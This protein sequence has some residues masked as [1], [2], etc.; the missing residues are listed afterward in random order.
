MDGLPDQ[1]PAAAKAAQRHRDGRRLSG[2]M[3]LRPLGLLLLALGGLA[4]APREPSSFVPAHGGANLALQGQRGRGLASR[5]AAEGSGAPAGVQPLGSQVLIE[6]VDTP[7][8]TAGGILLTESVKKQR[9]KLRSGIVRAKGS[10]KL[11][12]LRDPPLLEA[13]SVGDTVLWEDYANRPL[14]ED[15]KNNLFLIPIRS[16]KAKVVSS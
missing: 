7:S 14:S 12:D 3:A 9:S 10:G 15:P 1:L 16:I 5:A 8:E 4:I 11:G 13:L 2:K 6:E